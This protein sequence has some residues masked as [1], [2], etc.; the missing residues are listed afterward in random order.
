M[1]NSPGAPSAVKA[2]LTRFYRDVT[3]LPRNIVPWG[4][5]DY[6]HLPRTPFIDDPHLSLPPPPGGTPM[7]LWLRPQSAIRCQPR[8]PG[9]LI[10]AITR[11]P[12]DGRARSM[13]T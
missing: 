7:A 13:A 3:G 12:A 1:D 9:F 10:A 11:P 5:E 8:S 6:A 2:G 4:F